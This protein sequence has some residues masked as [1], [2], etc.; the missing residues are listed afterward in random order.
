MTN[1]GSSIACSEWLKIQIITLCYR[2]IYRILII[3]KFLTFYWTTV[4]NADRTIFPV[5]LE[6]N[7]SSFPLRL[8]S[9]LPFHFSD[10]PFIQLIALAHV[11]KLEIQ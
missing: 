8:H 6:W 4:Y 5:A 3:L 10:F 2:P 9:C 11:T 7:Y 1:S